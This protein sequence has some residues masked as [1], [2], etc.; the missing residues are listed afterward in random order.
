MGLGVGKRR[1]RESQAQTKIIPPRAAAG[2]KRRCRGPIK[3]RRRCGTMSP[4]KAME[5]PMATA[6]ATAK[7]AQI[8]IQRRKRERFTPRLI[9]S[10]SPDKSTSNDGAHHHQAAIKAT[11]NNGKTM[12]TCSIP[13]PSMPPRANNCRVRDNSRYPW[14]HAPIPAPMLENSIDSTTPASSTEVVS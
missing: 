4:T 6:D 11:R 14:A 7:V 8:M 5:P 12:R 2:N 9:A 3:P 10:S 1:I 13:L